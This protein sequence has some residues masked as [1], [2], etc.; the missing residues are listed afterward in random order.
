M[1]LC[2]FYNSNNASVYEDLREVGW[3]EGVDSDWKTCPEMVTCTASTTLLLILCFYGDCYGEGVIKHLV[4][5]TLLQNTV[6]LVK[7]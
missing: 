2:S 1:W 7:P 5:P 6:Q 4:L 3:V